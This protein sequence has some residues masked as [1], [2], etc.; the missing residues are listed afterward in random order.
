MEL[1]LL[2]VCVVSAFFLYKMVAQILSKW[3]SGAWWHKPLRTALGLG[4]GLVYMDFSGAYV[5]AKDSSGT[6]SLIVSFVPF[7]V[8]IAMKII[9]KTRLIEQ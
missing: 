9:R 1:I 2:V 6:L 3:L 4:V 7:V 5:M 8:Y